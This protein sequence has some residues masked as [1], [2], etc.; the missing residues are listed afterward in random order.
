M[1]A[2]IK[3]VVFLSVFLGAIYLSF[4]N[5]QIEETTK[6]SYSCDIALE[7]IA[8]ELGLCVFEDYSVGECY[9]DAPKN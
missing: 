6:S 1:D 4:I 3:I 8:D 9:P 5:V 2:F 7:A